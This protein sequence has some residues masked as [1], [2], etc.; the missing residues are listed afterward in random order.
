MCSDIYRRTSGGNVWLQYYYYY[1]YFNYS[2]FIFCRSLSDYRLKTTWFWKRTLLYE[3]LT[4]R[5]EKRSIKI[6]IHE[7]LIYVCMEYLKSRFRNWII[8]LTYF[9]SWVRWLKASSVGANTVN[10]PLSRRLYSSSVLV[11]SLGNCVNPRSFRVSLMFF[12]G[13]TVEWPRGNSFTLRCTP[14]AVGEHFVQLQI[15]EK[16]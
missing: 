2:F 11:R 12:T 15:L 8:Y 7:I 3:Y 10:A 5:Q 14:G 4:N 13:C 16:P 6:P 9:W 1:Y